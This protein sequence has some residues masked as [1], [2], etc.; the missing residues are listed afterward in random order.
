MNPQHKKHGVLRDL[1]DHFQSTM[2]R[3]FFFWE[4]GIENC[5][6]GTCLQPSQKNRKLNKDR[7]DVLSIP[8]Y[9]MKKG[10]SHGARHGPTER[11]RI[12]F[13]AH[14]A[15]RKEKKH[16]HKTI[17]VRFLNSL[18]YRDSQANMVWDEHICVLNSEGANGPVDQRNDHKEAK[19]TCDRLYRERAAAAGHVN[20][21]VHPQDQVRQRPEQQSEGH[22]DDFLSY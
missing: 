9:V 8:N 2:P 13:K 17:L 12:Y 21:R 4:L 6:C 22:E 16:G 18:L 15:L 7:F 20:T 10:P 1:R 3:F 5:T 14:N 11:Q 19:K